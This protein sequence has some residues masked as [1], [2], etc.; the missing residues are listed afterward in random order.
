VSLETTERLTEARAVLAKRLAA[1]EGESDLERVEALMG[2]LNDQRLELMRDRAEVGQEV[3]A[4]ATEIGRLEEE[5]YFAKHLEGLLRDDGLRRVVGGR[6]ENIL[7]QLAIGKQGLLGL[8][9][10]Q[11][12]SDEVI[13]EIG[14]GVGAAVERA[15]RRVLGS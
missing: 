1:L 6:R 13:R 15:R 10:L 4:L 7:A 5:A 9:L 8:Q 14:H 11:D 2:E 3:L 12:A